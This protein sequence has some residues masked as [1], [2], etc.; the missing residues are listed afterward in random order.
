MTVLL[1]CDTIDELTASKAQLTKTPEGLAP[2]GDGWF[3]VNVTDAR[4]ME[5]ELFGQAVRFAGD[6]PFPQFGFNIR[7]LQPGQPNCYYHRESNQEAFLVLD[8][9]CIAIIEDQERPMR[10]GDFL[11]MPPDVA[12]VFVGAG[13]GP[14]AILM[15]GARDESERVHY[16]VSEVAGR[17]GASVEEETDSPQAAYDDL[18]P[19]APAR[20][21]LR[22]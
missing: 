13:D 2:E 7:L 1:P 22:W 21:R 11:Y 19:P 5:S 15:V 20:V 17:Y 6:T 8:G 3:I 4:G 9:E 12:H 10:K 14:C 16:P 18:D